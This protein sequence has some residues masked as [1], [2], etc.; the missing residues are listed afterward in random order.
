MGS[1]EHV[2][3]TGER[4]GVGDGKWVFCLLTSSTQ[5]LHNPQSSQHMNYDI[6]IYQLQLFTNLN[7]L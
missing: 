2:A 7:L 4:G 1:S 5:P 6:Y 3:G